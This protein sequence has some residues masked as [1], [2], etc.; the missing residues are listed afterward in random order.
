MNNIFTRNRRIGARGPGTVLLAAALS[1][2]CDARR[3][4]P[5]AAWPLAAPA[6]LEGA[7]LLYQR[8]DGIWLLEIGAGLPRRLA[9]GG[10]WP[11][12]APDGRSF[13]FV[14]GNRILLRNLDNGAERDLAGADKPRA[15]AFH[16]EGREVWFTDG[17]RVRAVPIAG[18]S[19]RD[20]LSGAEFMELALSPD[21]RFVAATVRALGGYR[22]ARFDVP[23]GARRDLERGC[24]A[25][26]SA[27]G[28]CITVNR[29]GHDRLGLLDAETGESVGE[30]LAPPGLRLDNQ[31]WSNHPAWIAAVIE[32]DRQEVV[33][34]RVSDG[35]VWRVTD[36]GD[37]DRPDL[38]WVERKPPVGD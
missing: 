22:V 15:V 35:S 4:T 33:L 5:P 29:G 26:V 10:R 37:A 3:P 19:P 28:R 24:S 7:Q 25:G 13:A 31:Q 2:G 30:I 32:G 20:V 8:P 21:G 11:R 9:E 6:E 1:I 36:T 16:P 18:G 14:R 27:D 23:S 12:W 17:A 38:H 34:Q